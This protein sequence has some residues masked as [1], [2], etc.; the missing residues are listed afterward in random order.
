MF[1]RVLRLMLTSIIA[2]LEMNNSKNNARLLALGVSVKKFNKRIMEIVAIASISIVASSCTDFSNTFGNNLIP[3]DQDMDTR[4]DSSLYLRTS[5]FKVDSVATTNVSTVVSIGSYIDPQVGRVSSQ[6]F[7]NY[8]PYSF[9]VKNKTSIKDFGTDPVCDSI[10]MSLEVIGAK[11]D[12]VN[13]FDYEVYRVR[14]FRANPDTAYYTNFDMSPYLDATPMASFSSKGLFDTLRFSLPMDYARELV[15][16]SQED[17][18]YYDEDTLFHSRFNGLYIKSKSD[19]DQ[20]QAGNIINIDYTGCDIKLYYHNKNAESPDTGYMQYKFRTVSNQETKYN[21][22]FE[23][24]QHDYS[25][26]DLSIGGVDP[27][28]IGVEDANTEYCYAQGMAGVGTW[29]HIDMESVARLKRYVVDTMGY[30]T[31][32]IHRAELRF[33]MV[34][35]NWENYNKSYTKVGLYYNFVDAKFMPDYSPQIDDNEGVQGGYFGGRLNRSLG[36]Y[37]MDISSYM[38]RLIN[39]NEGKVPTKVQMLPY[40]GG[41][42]LIQRSQMYGSAVQDPK[43]RPQLI[44]TYTMLK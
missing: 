17:K 27:A 40:Y 22:S 16:L 18:K 36:Y 6:S 21:T 41:N 31:I 5:L 24:V 14:N 12:T 44:L 34:E 35:N 37:S 1:R 19:A 30:K 11:G 39:D 26:S 32:G 4:I 13:Y 10:V 8:V 43:H 7:S 29:V 9:F 28:L 3:P 20:T 2:Y 25:F 42:L 15:A 23:T 38:Q 33:K